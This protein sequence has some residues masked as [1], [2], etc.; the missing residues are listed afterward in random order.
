MSTN[1]K[2]NI[3]SAAILA[4]FL[5]SLFT[6]YELATG[7]DI[8]NWLVSASAVFAVL[9][10]LLSIF[11]THKIKDDYLNMA[12]MSQKIKTLA[13]FPEKNP[14]PI[15]EINKNLEVTY[16]NPAFKNTFPQLP[17]DHRFK[18]D[19]FPKALELITECFNKKKSQSFDHKINNSWFNFYVSYIEIS[20]KEFVRVFMH[21]ITEQKTIQE[22]LEI[23]VKGGH[24]GL[25]D[26][27]TV[28]N[29]VHFSDEWYTMLGYEP[30]E[31]PQEFETFKKL[32]HPED[33]DEAMSLL[34]KHISGQNE[35]YTHTMRMKRKD[36]SYAWVLTTGQIT[37]HDEQG[38]PLR[39]SGIHLDITNRKK[40]EQ[41]MQ[42]AKQFQ[43]LIHDNVPDLLFIKD[44]QFKIIQANSHFLNM[45]PEEKRKQVIGYTTIE[46]YNEEEAEEFLKK[47]RQALEEGSSETEET[48]TFPD[49]QIRT[50]FTKKVRFQ[51]TVGK[52]FIL[53]IGRDITKIKEAE[54]ALID[55]NHEME[56]FAYR[57]SHD[58]RSPIISSL[59][60]L[61]MVQDMIKENNID[62]AK[63]GIDHAKES[64][65]KL[66]KLIDDILQLT[67]VRRK[68]EE[69]QTFTM[70]EL[71]DESIQKLSHLEGFK[72]ID[73]KKNL[74]FGKPVTTK[75]LHLSM[76]FENI[77]S[78]A[79]KYQDTNEEKPFVKIETREE[80]GN[81]VLSVTDNGIGIPRDQ[82]KN[83]FKMF[84]RFHPKVAYGSGL[85]LYLIKK[86]AEA[87]GASIEFKSPSKGTSFILKVPTKE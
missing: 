46:D 33:F 66:K 3:L 81:F 18:T 17:L 38:N 22:R 50:L 45:Y 36:G 62:D 10:I 84:K 13:T 49:G 78:N 20:K 68:D 5:L 77:F 15:I 76:I 25:W 57:T 11:I 51:N 65:D 40:A 41:E 63:D 75:K 16:T 48:L 82:Q 86:S 4:F 14:H 30:S 73:I 69:D 29:D 67:M 47:D 43:E 71:I 39:A 19:V 55:T 1:A 52:K 9:A 59:S 24:I 12:V 21:D 80:G 34:E 83:M 64:L 56:E 79:I 35:E 23:T 61:E 72:N 58:L 44:D 26:W 28:S 53:G 6:T 32:C 27:N 70:S 37:E 2:L 8:L 74:K 42:D 54:Q 87:I 31:I 85:G 60:L 7:S